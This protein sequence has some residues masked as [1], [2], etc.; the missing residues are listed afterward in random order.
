MLNIIHLNDWVFSALFQMIQPCNWILSFSFELR[1]IYQLVPNTQH[2]T[3]KENHD[4]SHLPSAYEVNSSARYPVWSSNQH[5][6]LPQST[7]HFSPDPLLDHQLL[8]QEWLYFIFS[9]WSQGRLRLWTCG[10][11]SL[12]ILS[13]E[14]IVNCNF[15]INSYYWIIVNCDCICCTTHNCQPL[16]ILVQHKMKIR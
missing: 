14:L 10:Q 13:A 15:S 9:S 3:L 5:T 16:E 11:R 2:F 6:I 7:L 1:N 12:L 8:I 4:L